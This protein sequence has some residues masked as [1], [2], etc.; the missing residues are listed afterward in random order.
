MIEVHKLNGTP[1]LVNPD[2]IRFI[3]STPDTVLTFND[4]QKL[5]VRNKIKEILDKIIEYRRACNS[6]LPVA[7]VS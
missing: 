1:I 2:L 7:V 6:A 4:G 3:E 5:M